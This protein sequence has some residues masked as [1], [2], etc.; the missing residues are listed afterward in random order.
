MKI[1]VAGDYCPRD[2]VA[3]QIDGGNFVEVLSDIKLV[4]EEADYSIVN[5]ECPV[6]SKPYKSMV[7][8]AEIL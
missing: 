5:F 6:V 3:K 1:L 8:V 7:V 2:R 4:T